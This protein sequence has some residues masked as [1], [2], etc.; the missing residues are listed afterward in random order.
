MKAAD[1]G[2]DCIEFERLFKL[3]LLLSSDPV[4]THPDLNQVLEQVE[5][6][7]TRHGDVRA[8]DLAA[9]RQSLEG[10][11]PLQY[12]WRIETLLG[13]LK[14]DEHPCKFLLVKLSFE[15][16][17]DFLKEVPIISL[18]VLDN[19]CITKLLDGHLLLWVAVLDSRH[20]GGACPIVV[21]LLHL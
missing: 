10:Q 4:V 6:L 17:R 14:V 3:W 12:L 8:V 19:G 16:R 21:E 18:L 2:A 5:S 9:L 13:V 20:D 1:L 7:E 11:T 15:R